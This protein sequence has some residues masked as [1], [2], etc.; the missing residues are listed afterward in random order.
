M[1][2]KTIC[3]IAAV[4]VLCLALPAFGAQVTF[5]PRLT[6][7]EEYTD[8][9]FRDPEIPE[10]GLEPE[11]DFIS[12]ISPGATLGFLGQRADLSIAYDPYYS[13]YKNNTYLSRWSQVANLIGNWQMT[14]NT[15][16]FLTDNFIYTE[17]PQQEDAITG[18]NSRNP[19]YRNTSVIGITNQFGAR[20]FVTLQY[21]HMEFR[22]DTEFGV[23][24]DDSTTYNPELI[25]AYWFNTR[26]GFDGRMAYTKGQFEITEDFEN[27]YADLRLLYN[28]SRKWDFF[29]RY[30]HTYQDYMEESEDYQIYYPSLGFE[31]TY[32]DT[33]FLSLEGGPLVRDYEDR[34]EEY[35]YTI[36]AD[37][38]K[39][40]LFPRGNIDIYIS[41]GLDYD[42][43]STQNLG[44][45]YYTEAGGGAS[46]SFYRNFSGNINGSY[47]YNAYVDEEPE[48]NDHI[49]QA[50][51]G[52]QW[53]LTYYCSLRLN[54]TFVDR[55]SNDEFEEYAENRVYLGVSFF[56]RSPFYIK[57]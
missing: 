40:W 5:S 20:D 13:D 31:Y 24:S 22:E 39:S 23:P 44:L 1:P 11:E 54:Y 52:L 38:R 19:Y 16:A 14:K 8:N 25:L 37:G 18:R 49:Y 17:D 36:F 48:R 47:R 27:I 41:N 3:T 4:I 2:I 28:Y 26:W 10:L 35:G 21:T 32:D 51:A 12:R 7:S 15:R 33:T 29:F 45:F 34:S 57:R 46:Y 43:V 6:L 56:P 50:G 9:V 55:Q 53:L 42:Y 30:A